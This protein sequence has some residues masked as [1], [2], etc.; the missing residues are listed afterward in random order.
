MTPKTLTS[1]PSE[2]GDMNLLYPGD[3]L[4]LPKTRVVPLDVSAQ[5]TNVYTAELQTVSVRVQ[6][7]VNGKPLT[8][9]T[10]ERDPSC[11]DD[12]DT[13]TDGQ[14]FA[15]VV[16]STFIKEFRI[17]FSSP[18]LEYW[19]Q[20]ARLNPVETISG[21]VQRLTHLGCYQPLPFRKSSLSREQSVALALSRAL[22]AFQE[23]QGLPITAEAD[24]AT[25]TALVEAFG[26]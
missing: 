4:F 7:V 11:T 3:L 26:S 18:D 16:V 10:F 2:I 9:K 24:A 13:Q 22:A 5:S 12:S 8:G 6:F 17:R 23:H 20:V 25:R 14:G 1:V 21:Q 19:I 15:T